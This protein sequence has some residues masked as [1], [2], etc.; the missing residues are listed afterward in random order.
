MEGR[1]K[2][3]PRYIVSIIYANLHIYDI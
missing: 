2:S 3:A 1:K